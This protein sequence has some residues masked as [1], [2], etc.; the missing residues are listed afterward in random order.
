MNRSEWFE[1]KW[2][3]LRRLALVALIG[4]AAMVIGAATDVVPLAIVGGIS[5]IPLIF[6]VAFI[7]ILHWKERY[8][9]ARSTVWGAFLVFETSSWSKLFYWFFH[10]LPDWRRSG[11]YADA[12]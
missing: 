5:I 4:V 8:I 2:R 11:Q 10:V 1:S 9:G 3:W 6:W 7:P 12:P